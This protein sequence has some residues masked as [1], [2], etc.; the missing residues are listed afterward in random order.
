MAVIDRLTLNEL[1]TLLQFFNDVMKRGKVSYNR[2][3]IVFVEYL[4]SLSNKYNLSYN[5]ESKLLVD[6]FYKNN[7]GIVTRCL[8]D[9]R[10]YNLFKSHLDFLAGT[11]DNKT[12]KKYYPHRKKKRLTTKRKKNEQTKK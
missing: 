10:E 12:R 7:P 4:Y 2:E 11:V 8:H 5:D 6:L 1:S 9:T 3:Y